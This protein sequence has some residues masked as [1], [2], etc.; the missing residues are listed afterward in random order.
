MKTINVN[1]KYKNFLSK[2]K[3]RNIKI[4]KDNTSKIKD[5]KYTKFEFKIKHFLVFNKNGFLLINS[6]ISDYTKLSPKFLDA[7]KIFIMKVICL[8]LK[9]F[10]IFFKHNK[11]F[12][13]N[14]NFIYVVILANKYNSCLVRL[15][16]F[17][18][19]VVFINLL[20][21]N[22]LNQTYVNLSTISKILEVYYIPPI[23]FKFTNAIGYILSK[24]E[25]N[26]SKYLYKFKNLLIYC[27]DNNG[28]IF[29]LF[30][31]RKVI[32]YKE[33]KYKY[34]I[35][36]SENVLNFITNL[37]LEPNYN[38]NYINK[39]E[40]Y[41][42]SMELVSTFPRLMILGKYLK[43][44]DGIIFL[45]VY[46]SKKLSRI[47]KNYLE[48]EIKQQ[49][50]IDDYY[51]ISSK[52]SKKF[53]KLIEFFLYNYF[54]TITDIMNKY[55]NP[56]NELLYFDIDLLIVTNDVIS[57]KVNEDSL[58]NLVYKRLQLNR[59][60]MGK[61]R[62]SILLEEKSE[63]SNSNS[64]SSPDSNKKSNKEKNKI[65]NSIAI[66]KSN[67]NLKKYD[68]SV[69]KK[70]ESKIESSSDISVS[71]VSKS[72]LQLDISDVF[73]EL[74]RK[75]IQ[76]SSFDSNALYDGN[77]E[78]SEI[79]NISCIKNSNQNNNNYDL[80]SLFSNIPTIPGDKKVSGIDTLSFLEKKE[81][82]N[83]SRRQTEKQINIFKGHRN[84]IGPTFN[85]IVNNNNSNNKDIKN[86]KISMRSLNNRRNFSVLYNNKNITP[87]PAKIKM[88]KNKTKNSSFNINRNSNFFK[89]SNSSTMSGLYLNQFYS[90][91]NNNPRYFKSKHQIIKEIQN[92]IKQ[93]Y[94]KKSN[95]LIIEKKEKKEKKE[96]KNIKTIKQPLLEDE[97]DN[98]KDLL[99]EYYEDKSSANFLQNE[100]NN[101]VFE[102]LNEKK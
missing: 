21:D 74:K 30:D 91:I 57:L 34:N 8:D 73:R 28:F 26:S 67:N 76:L 60:K 78:L 81:N 25:T 82:Q 2:L 86:R 9:Y 65:E 69:N 43:I 41:S 37:I 59:L 89:R 32:H 50:N 79:W 64:N 46:T 11:I 20:G 10:E 12:I 90:L 35:R 101:S 61:G 94:T 1:N 99:Q 92:K 38:N 6:S 27:I 98:K 42:H 100:N 85:I 84:S 70:S 48:Y 39:N 44:F 87:S 4:Q 36:K 47:S 83:I 51:K 45:Q 13:L 53:L 68:N 62:S 66:K 17:F 56:S 5:E 71:S 95:S 40:I 63:N 55:C 33:L 24:K 49:L 80:H 102:K 31:Y 52:H 58:V 54:E 97:Q 14:K 22:I 88:N 19:N 77:D 15:Y 23:T 16:L 3:E 18:F 29:P 93:S 7:I 96:N 72:F 75:S